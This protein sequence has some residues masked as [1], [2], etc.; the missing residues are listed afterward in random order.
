MSISG[1]IHLVSTDSGGGHVKVAT[2]L[3][4]LRRHLHVLNEQVSIGPCDVDTER[5]F[6]LR[7]AWNAEIGHEYKN[8]FGLCELR[9]AI[10]GDL[11][12]VIWA[13][14]AY[15]DLVWLWWILDGLVQLGPLASPPVIVRPIADDPHEDVG[16]IDPA[17]GV[18]ALAVAC[19]IS[20]DEIREGAE[21][22]K[23]FASPDPRDFDEARRRGSLVFPELHESADLHGA[24]FPRIEDGRLRL[25]EYDQCLL[26]SLTDEW[27]RP[28]DLMRS[29]A[30]V[31]ELD[32][33]LRT[34]GAYWIPIWRLRAWAARGTI[35]SEFR[36]YA[37]GNLLEQDVFRLTD[38]TRALLETGMETVGDPPPVYVGGCKLH[39]PAAPWV[40]V[41]DGASWRITDHM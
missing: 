34:F 36:D 15:S 2:R 13:T 8:T 1:A 6:D 5:H 17:K 23:L 4:G 16:G 27:M 11:P 35:Q 40:R 19:P 41:P 18:D 26:A 29:L 12:I 3:A 31:P 24:W 10:H 20:E 30:R 7:R 38:K 32:R 37:N 33:L 9:E 25:S 39:D 14:H 28:C 22:W 21:L